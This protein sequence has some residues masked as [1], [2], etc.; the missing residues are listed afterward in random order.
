MKNSTQGHPTDGRTNVSPSTLRRFVAAAI[1]AHQ[2]VAST[3]ALSLS[4]VLLMAF[5]MPMAT[6]HPSATLA[7]GSTTTVVAT[8]R[9]TSTTTKER[10]IV[11]VVSHEAKKDVK[12]TS[13]KTHVVRVTA[14][15]VTAQTRTADPKATTIPTP[16]PATDPTTTTVPIA[17]TT[18]PTPT[19]TSTPTPTATTTSTTTTTVAPK[20]V[21]TTTVPAKAPVAHVTIANPTVNLAPS[22]NFLQSGNC[23]SGAGGW[24]CANPCVTSAM[25][26]PTY[27]NG[28]ACT[29][30][31]LEAINAGRSDEGLAPMVLPT[32]WYSLSVG[33]QL[34]VVA[35]LERTARGLPAYLGLNAALSANAQRAA[36]TDSDPS[37][38]SGFDIGTDAQGSPG[39]GGAWSAGFSVLAADYI[40][41]YDDGWG[42]SVAATS[43][44]VCTSAKAAGC[45]AHRD[46]LLGSD[47]GY[48]PGVGLN[49][50]DCEMGTGFAVVSGSGSFVDLVELPKGT[51]PAMTFTWAQELSEGY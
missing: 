50:T 47:P 37:V 39:M 26:W 23:T 2:V 12:A 38:A 30:Y 29:N 17:T 41:M 40:W 44:V 22:P 11:R 15:V 33:Q 19:P 34:F 49:C 43:N 45:W 20:P 6:V 18:T 1:R 42:G 14:H 16:K 28:A 32:N 21:T 31:V 3:I 7:P 35:N 5:A 36:Q 27:T 10:R 8:A 48:N 13:A 4:A 25:T 9:V 46:E 51:P 24:S